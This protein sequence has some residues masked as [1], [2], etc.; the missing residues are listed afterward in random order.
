MWREDG[1]WLNLNLFLFDI[2]KTNAS[3]FM[4]E[5]RAVLVKMMKKMVKERGEGV[6]LRKP[7]SMYIRGRSLELYK[8]KVFIS[9][10]F[11]S[12]LFSSLLFSSLLF[13]SLLF[14]SLLF[15]SLL[16]S[17]PH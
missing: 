5:S 9:F 7:G 8:Y 16:F 6:I 10:L 2:V 15:S 4:C 13:S 12:L 14:S 11:S 17:I 3:R 1:E